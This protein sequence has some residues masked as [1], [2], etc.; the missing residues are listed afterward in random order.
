MKKIVIFASAL[1]LCVSAF[2]Q[3]PKEGP[4]KPFESHFKFYGFVRNYYAFDTRESSAGTEDLYFYMPKDQNIVDGEDMNAVPSFRYA[5]LTSRVGVDVFGYEVAGYKV[6]AKIEADFYCGVSGVTGTAQLRL[7]QAYATLAKDGRAW[8]LGQAWHPM[9]ADLPDIFSLESGAPFGPFSRTP[10]ITLDYRL[11]DDL[12]VTASA[13]WQMQYTS[14]GP[15]LTKGSDGLYNYSTAAASA[16]YIKYGVI[17]ELYLGLNY[18]WKTNLLRVGADLL[19]I[20][21]RNYDYDLTTGKAVGKVSDRLTTINFFQY[22]QFKVGDWTLKEKITYAN[23]GSH[24]NMVGGYGVSQINSDGSWDYSAS[25]NIS[26]WF[27]AQY[28]SKTSKWSPALLLGY[29]KAFGTKD[30]IVGDFWCKN[31]ANSV[32]QMFRIQPEIVYNLGKVAFGL[33]YMATGVQYGKA[34]SHKLAVDNL[35]WVVNH[36]LQAMIKYTF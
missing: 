14:T 35:H 19:S 28:K 17:P 31:S 21:P 9:A 11:M 36:R 30:E 15:S 5:A 4:A 7:R 33:E 32:A 27:T 16:N 10:Q 6:G 8:K 34:N 29:I 3:G 24:F 26:G 25:R 1:A 2:A 23:D 12:S 18:K 13:I 20:K 22:G